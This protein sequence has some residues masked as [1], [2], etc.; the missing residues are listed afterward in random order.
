MARLGTI[1]RRTREVEIRRDGRITDILST[2]CI[3]TD[4]V[5]VE[6]LALI[7]TAFGH[8]GVRYSSFGD[9]S[10]NLPVS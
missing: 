2:K 4:V 8:P 6:R 5:R 3:S 9:S 1:W 7:V 10:A